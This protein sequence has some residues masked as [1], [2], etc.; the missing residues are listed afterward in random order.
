[1]IVID[2]KVVTNAMHRHVEDAEADSVTEMNGIMW[3]YAD[4]YYFDS[5]EL[6]LKIWKFNLDVFELV[7]YVALLL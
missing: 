5:K 2:K 3:P 7:I 1:M 6:Y 4:I